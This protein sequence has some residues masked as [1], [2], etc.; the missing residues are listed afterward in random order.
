MNMPPSRDFIEAK[1]LDGV[2]E[3]TQYV[4]MYG[5]ETYDT[6]GRKVKQFDFTQMTYLPKYTDHCV[7]KD[8][9]GITPYSKLLFSQLW[10]IHMLCDGLQFSVPIE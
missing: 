8:I 3:L 9:P 7:V 2:D 4:K 6:L 5:E 1:N 10:M